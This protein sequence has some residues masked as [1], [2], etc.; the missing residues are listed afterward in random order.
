MVD[1]TTSRAR[2]RDLAC[3]GRARL[4]AC[5]LM[6]ST[7]AV[8]NV[9]PIRVDAAQREALVQR[10]GA[11]DE[12]PTSAVAAQHRERTAAVEEALG[13]VDAPG[14]M[15]RGRGGDVGLRRRVHVDGHEGAQLVG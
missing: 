5:D 13:V 14:G 12:E 4:E 3:R 8:E 1:P 9:A 2:L 10:A 7:I 11:V 6:A 15:I